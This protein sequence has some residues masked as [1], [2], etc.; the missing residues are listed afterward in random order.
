MQISSINIRERARHVNLVGD[1]VNLDVLDKL[2]SIVKMSGISIREDFRSIF[3][4][5]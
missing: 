5:L 4:I 3:N 1:Y 2:W